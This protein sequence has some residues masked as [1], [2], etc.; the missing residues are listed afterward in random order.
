MEDFLNKLERVLIEFKINTESEETIFV[1]KLS[2]Y[3]DIC[4]NQ[5]KVK[6]VADF[7]SEVSKT[8]D[9]VKISAFIK[10]L[11]LN[12]I[13][14][15]FGK[16]NDLWNGGDLGHIKVFKDNLLACTFEPFCDKFYLCNNERDYIALYNELEGLKNTPFFVP[17]FFY[18]SFVIFNYKKWSSIHG[19]IECIEP[20][21]FQ[22]KIDEIKRYF[23]RFYKWQEFN[24][25]DKKFIPKRLH[26]TFSFGKYK[27]QMLKN[28]LDIDP[29]Y[30]KWQI[31]NNLYFSVSYDVLDYML[32]VSPDSRNDLLIFLT[33]LKNELANHDSKLYFH[34]FP[35]KIQH[36]FYGDIY[37][38][39]WADSEQRMYEEDMDEWLYEEFDG[40]MDLL[41]WN[42]E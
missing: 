2:Q 4:E 3:L 35:T 38:D 36:E 14:T 37:F 12:Y 11:E 18:Y 30:I 42:T 15:R 24:V 5:Y 25:N 34:H 33:T 40:D 10:L 17:R 41:H 26:Y 32:S 23:L 27:G 20:S 13:H 8:E 19:I 7:C 6:I 29:G 1:N 22:I 21:T 28:I 31:L 16:L 9:K 39:D